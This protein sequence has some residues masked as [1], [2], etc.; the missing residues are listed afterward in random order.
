MS[1]TPDTPLVFAIDTCGHACSI[2]L[3][4]AAGACLFH[5]TQWMA[6]GHGA[7]LPA[8][9]AAALINTDPARIQ[10]LVVT[11]GPGGFTGMRAGLAYARAFALGRG[12][13]AFGLSVDATLSLSLE[14][15]TPIAIDSRRGDFFLSGEVVAR[16]IVEALDGPVAGSWNLSAS[17]E[18]IVGWH[19]PCPLAMARHGHDLLAA[20]A[21]PDAEALEPLYIRAPSVG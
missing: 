2:A 1:V 14:P 4:P 20:Q 15:Q 11:R 6:R 18:A 5:E 7:A 12:I 16:P 8:M 17:P 21:P 19:E 13:P 10:A 9:A 3:A